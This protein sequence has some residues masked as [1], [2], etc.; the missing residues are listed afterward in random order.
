M[1]LSERER[2]ILDFE[3][4]WCKEVGSKAEAVRDRF[5][6]SSS[7]YY[8]L[9][10]RIV[11]SAEAD[12]YDPLVA[13]RIRRMRIDRRRARF[14]GSATMRPTGSYGGGIPASDGGGTIFGLRRSR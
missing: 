14:E 9:L 4:G 10:A 8:Q 5:G 2:A 7:R 11:D 13:R 1:G 12:V 3:R 6:L